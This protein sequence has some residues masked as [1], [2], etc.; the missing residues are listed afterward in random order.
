[1]SENKFENRPDEARPAMD[2]T[3]EDWAAVARSLVWLLWRIENG[4]DSPSVDMLQPV[5]KAFSAS[6]TAPTDKYAAESDTEPARL[7]Q[8][9]SCKDTAF[10]P[11]NHENTVE[12]KTVIP[13]QE[14]LLLTIK[15]A[16]AYSN[17]GI[18]RI[19]AMLKEAGCPFVLYVGSRKLV[20]RQEFKDYIAK[21]HAV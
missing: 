1:M 3:Q 2:L 13:I 18:N 4:A 14:K 8:C 21:R 5:S 7:L 10:T 17:I 19:E 16:S 20:K 11:S 12:N 6:L 15:E 9:I